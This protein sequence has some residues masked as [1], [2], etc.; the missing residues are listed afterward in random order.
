MS[1]TSS[2]DKVSNRISPKSNRKGLIIGI[3]VACVVIAIIVVVILIV[4][5]PKAEV[6]SKRNTVVTPEN[7]EEILNGKSDSVGAGSYNAI[8]NSEWVFEN[9]SSASTNAYV[10]NSAANVNDVYFD[11]VRND[12]GET[13]LTSPVIPVGSHLS[14][15]TLDKAL[16]AGTYDCTVIYYLLDDNGKTLSQ[17]QISL[18]IVVVK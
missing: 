7:I 12:T 9:G 14:D 6:T 11:I 15:I 8:M 4:L 2:N 5:R 17:V 3:I 16:D 10:E 18:T 13:I 1:N